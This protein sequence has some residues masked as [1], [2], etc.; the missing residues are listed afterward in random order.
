MKASRRH[1][2]ATQMAAKQYPQAKALL[3]EWLAQ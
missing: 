2:V 1:L 3:Q